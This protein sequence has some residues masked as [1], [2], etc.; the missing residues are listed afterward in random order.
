[1][2]LLARVKEI[3]DAHLADIVNLDATVIAQK[4]KLAPYI[5]E[6]RQNIAGVLGVEIDRVNVKATTEEKLGFTGSG[7]GMAVHA[8]ALLVLKQ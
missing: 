3:A 8:I 6:M 1:M 7:E 5:E 2:R 4:P